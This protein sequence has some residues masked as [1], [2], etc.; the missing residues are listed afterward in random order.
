MNKLEEIKKA[1]LHLFA[2]KGYAETSM[3]D[4]ADS[5]E[6]NKA[7]LYFYIKSKKDLYLLVINEQFN[8]YQNG[9]INIFDSIKDQPLEHF[10]YELTKMIVSNSTAEGILFWR[11]SLIMAIS[12]ID[13]DIQQSL[14]RL[15][16]G[17]DGHIKRL[18]ESLLSIKKIT[19]DDEKISIFSISFLYFIKSLLDWRLL[20]EDADVDKNLPA[21]W[22]AFW[23][24][25]KLEE[26]L[27]KEE[28]NI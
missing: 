13:D 20:Y 18:I 21:F 26:R 9:F 23:N 2:T 22:N 16:L 1:S 3:Q 24:G 5:V 7:S 28:L 11:R 6:L 10:L 25:C 8:N 19:I 14:K 12:D 15:L 27:S 17:N 4:I